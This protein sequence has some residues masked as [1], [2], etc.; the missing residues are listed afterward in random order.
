MKVLGES[1][2]RHAEVNP[3]AYDVVCA[4][5]VLE[6][7]TSI[8]SFLTGALKAVKPGG[9][10]LFSVPNNEPYFQ[11]FAKYEVLNLPPH[12]VGLWNFSSLQKLCDFYDMEMISHKATGS[13]PLLS[14]AYLRAKYVGGVK[15]LPRRETFA[16]KAR[17]Y[18]TAPYTI[19]RSAI[20]Y[21]CGNPNQA[22]ISVTFR[23]NQGGI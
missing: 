2:E 18:F 1:I 6:H 8:Q 17:I 21:A 5:Q 20:D 22:F 13:A 16:E 15:S 19:L 7:V 14:D 10:L 11:R 3:E 12:H 4:F 9:R 23:K